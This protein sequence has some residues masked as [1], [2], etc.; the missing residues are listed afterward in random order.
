MFLFFQGYP[1]NDFDEPIWLGRI[2]PNMVIDYCQKQSIWESDKRI[3]LYGI[4]IYCGDIGVM[5]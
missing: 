4:M 3:K 1:D 5:I 2:S